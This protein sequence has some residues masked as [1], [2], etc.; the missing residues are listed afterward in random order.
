MV[1]LQGQSPVS[2]STPPTGS[3]S[4]SLRNLMQL[5]AV[6]YLELLK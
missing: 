2:R 4:I 1:E 6:I 5:S 3:I